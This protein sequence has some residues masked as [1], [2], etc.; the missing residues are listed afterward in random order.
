MK[1]VYLALKMVWK[2]KFLNLF[3]IV[4]IVLSIYYL[5][6]ILSQTLHYADASQTLSCL[7]MDHSYYLYSNPRYSKRDAGLKDSLHAKIAS[8][9]Y[10]TG[11]AE[12]YNLHSADSTYH[13]ISYNDTLIN[14]FSPN[15]ESG[16]WLKEAI[17][18]DQIPIVVSADTAL[19]CGEVLP[20][21][22]VSNDKEKSFTCVVVGIIKAKTN[23][24]GFS[25]AADDA[26][27]TADALLSNAAYT[28]ILPFTAE[29]E[30]FISDDAYL[31]SANGSILYTSAETTYENV[32]KDFGYAGIVT[33]LGS[34]NNRFY[35]QSR[36]IVVAMGAYFM[37]YLTITILCLLCSNFI[38]N[39]SMK[40]NYTIYFLAGMSYMRRVAI[41]ITR[42][43]LL[44]FIST[45]ISF[46]FLYKSGVI[47]SYFENM[48]SFFILAVI[49]LYIG[50]IFLPVSAAFIIKNRKES[51]IDSIRNLNTEL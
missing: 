14:N 28:I 10:V 6:P 19:K 43:F 50:L 12:C 9:A 24:M 5:T 21:E 23:V 11:H 7:E 31:L 41:E 1:V 34:G 8:T 45:T 3:L 26:Y 30:N 44:I 13:I 4:T 25:S 47:Q 42:I 38:L 51:I 46:L 40:R 27:F 49:L 15:L 37:L 17:S 39:I 18:T 22:L 33:D 16:I 35:E 2:Q 32:L 36:L 29:I 48:N 20:L